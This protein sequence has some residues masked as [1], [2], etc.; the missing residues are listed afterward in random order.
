MEFRLGEFM[1]RTFLFHRG[2]VGSTGKAL[3]K[4]NL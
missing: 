1:G 2:I 3:P 4:T